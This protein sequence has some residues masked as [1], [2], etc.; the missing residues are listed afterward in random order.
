MKRLNYLL[1]FAI[2]YIIFGCT[3][4]TREGLQRI[5]FSLDDFEV[6]KQ[7]TGEKFVYDSILNPR[8]ILLKRTNLIVSNSGSRFL[9]HVIDPSSMKYQTGKGLIGNGPGEITVGIWELDGGLDDDSFWAYDL[10]GKRFYEFNLLSDSK[11]ASRTIKQNEAWFFGHSMHWKSRNEIISY[12]IRSSDEFGVFDTLGNRTELIRPWSF[13]EEVDEQMG[14][15]LAGLY[16]GPIDYHSKSKI[17]GHAAIKFEYFELINLEDKNI[18]E[19]YGPNKSQLNYELETQDGEVNA[20]ITEE[21]I[22]GYSD[23]F[24][25]EESVFLAYIGKTNH[26][27]RELGETTNMIFEFD[28]NGNPKSLFETDIAVRYLTVSETDRIIY[29][30]SNDENPG[31]VIFEY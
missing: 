8:R 22:K 27:E 16:Q 25:G 10:S 13:E 7:L 2:F 31:I 14:Y 20:F 11:L 3:E 4:T 21:T 6:K 26:E 23:I 29:G 24:I 15:V 1:Y 30:I 5:E 28:L 18:L 17:L 19:F 12:L 9:L